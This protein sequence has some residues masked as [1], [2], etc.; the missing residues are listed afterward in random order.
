MT[1]ALVLVACLLAPSLEAQG[2]KPPRPLASPTASDLER[3]HALFDVQCA[4]CHGIG[5]TGGMGP[6]LAG[7][8]LRRAGDE[9]ALIALLFEGVPGTA[10]GRAWQLSEGELAQVAAYVTSLGRV[11]AAPLP[12]DPVRGKAIY[13]GRVA[14]ATCHI[15]RGVG[16]G[17]GPELT[18]VGRRRGA[19]HLRQSILDPGAHLPERRVPYE[20]NIYAA[21]LVVRAVPRGGAEIMGTRVNEDSFTIQVRDGA[22][23]LHSLRKAD[24]STLEKQ[25]ATSL[26]PSY[27]GA[28]TAAEVDDLVAYLMTLRGEP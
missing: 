11:P 5:G 15:V 7:A 19:D 25:E 1:R 12:G 22:G 17:R 14:C 2:V 26:M 10:M 4:R 23:R 13:D 20:P 28:L 8:K 27:R 18:E 16:S 6:P 24:L 3:G 9:E 21:Y